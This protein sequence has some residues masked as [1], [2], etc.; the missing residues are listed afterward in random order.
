MRKIIQTVKKYLSIQDRQIGEY[1]QA[2]REAYLFLIAP[3]YM[4]TDHYKRFQTQETIDMAI[5]NCFNSGNISTWE[6]YTD[7]IIDDKILNL[8]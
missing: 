8:Y 4:S 2:E 5:G 1:S 7:N 3:L 6:Q